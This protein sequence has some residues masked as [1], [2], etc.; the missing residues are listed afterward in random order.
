MTTTTYSTFEFGKKT[1]SDNF[2]APPDYKL[3]IKNQLREELAKDVE[4]FLK[5]NTITV[6]PFG[7]GKN[8]FKYD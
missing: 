3:K 8:I 6:I 4:E 2:D 1:E 5:T 7:V